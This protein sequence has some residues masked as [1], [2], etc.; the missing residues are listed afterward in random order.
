VTGNTPLNLGQRH[1]E[2]RHTVEAQ[3]DT[4][5]GRVVVDTRVTKEIALTVF[6][7]VDRGADTC[8]L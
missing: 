7:R 3:S 1:P 5:D 2:L 4:A 8:P 6:R